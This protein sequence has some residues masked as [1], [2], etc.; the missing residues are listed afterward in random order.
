MLSIYF[1]DHENEVYDPAT[2]FINKYKDE[3]ITNE[4]SK[5]MIRDVDKSE[6]LA[7]RIIDSPFLGAITPRELSGGVKTLMLMKFDQSDWIFNGSACGD[8]CA[9]WLLEIADRHEEDITINLHHLMNFDP[10][11]KGTGFE[12]R[13]AN[14]G[15]IVHNME[16]Y[17]IAAGTLLGKVDKP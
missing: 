13:I 9:K 6:V 15:E 12:I 1:G 7:A 4:L 17:V 5:E 14:T 8:N 3:W 11:N 2:Y 10:E 16:E